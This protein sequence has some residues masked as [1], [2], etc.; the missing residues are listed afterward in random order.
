M[1]C[2]LR[3]SSAVVALGAAA[4]L[5]GGLGVSTAISAAPQSAAD[6]SKVNQGDANKGAL[7]ADQQKMNKADQD[8]TKKIRQSIMQDKA[9]STYAHNVKIISQNGDVTLKGPVRTG[10]EKSS[11]ESKAAAVVGEA[12]VKSEIQIVPK[13]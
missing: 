11:I 4:L 2:F 1:K 8:I 12:H 7:T 5:F 9:L 10:E 13:S 6:N 3:V